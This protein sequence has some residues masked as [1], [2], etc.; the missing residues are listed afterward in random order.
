MEEAG[1][2][3]SGGSGMGDGIPG[4]VVLECGGKVD[5]GSCES[6]AYG[7]GVSYR[8]LGVSSRG[9][10]TDVKT[11]QIEESSRY[12]HLLQ[13]G[14]A[15]IYLYA[16]SSSCRRKNRKCFN[17]GSCDEDG[18]SDRANG[19]RKVVPAT[20]GHH[21]AVKADWKMGKQKAT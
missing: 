17:S 11:S 7:L 13:I 1:M 12:L 4:I 16:T 19:M 10:S 3:G 18:C 8:D 14:R 5:I 9:R 15:E 6:C 2:W 21:E 20:H